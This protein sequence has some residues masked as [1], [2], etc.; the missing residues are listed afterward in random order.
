MSVSM[1]QIK[2]RCWIQDSD[3]KE[4]LDSKLLNLNISFWAYLKRFSWN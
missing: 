4:M 1:I 2:K 3:K